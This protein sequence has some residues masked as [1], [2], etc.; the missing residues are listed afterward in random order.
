M[1]ELELWSLLDEVQ[2][3]LSEHKREVLYPDFQLAFTVLCLTVLTSAVLR[4]W[5]CSSI[6]TCLRRCFRARL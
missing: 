4:L 3:F 5:W 1:G 2:T 6:S